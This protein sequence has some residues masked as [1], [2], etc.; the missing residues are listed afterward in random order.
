MP[1]KKRPQ[2]YKTAPKN[3]QDWDSHIFG[4]EG[5]LRVRMDVLDAEA[6]D[7]GAAQATSSS[8]ARDHGD[9]STWVLPPHILAHG[10]VL[11]N[12]FLD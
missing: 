2:I 6:I 5:K 3:E 12:G 8:Q 10:V 9:S 1:T 11:K 4:K 7:A